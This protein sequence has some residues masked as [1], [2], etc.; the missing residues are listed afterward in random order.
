MKTSYVSCFMG[1]IQGKRN[2]G[3][4]GRP[5]LR[6]IARMLALL[7]CAALPGTPILADGDSQGYGPP[8]QAPPPTH[9]AESDDAPRRDIHMGTVD[10]MRFGRDAEGNE[11]ME[12]K[13]RSKKAE[14]QPQVGPFFI[15]PQVGVPG[16]TMPMGG[17]SGR[18]GQTGQTMPVGGQSGQTRQG[19]TSGQGTSSSVPQPRSAQ[20]ISPGSQTPGPRTPETGQGTG[21]TTVPAPQGR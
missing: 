17:Q 8:P 11:V 15:Y 20:G 5:S 1:N 9:D 21:S 14:E 7:L 12:V 3:A 18:T 19:A 4:R 2:R 6:R 16:Q 10:N 13:A